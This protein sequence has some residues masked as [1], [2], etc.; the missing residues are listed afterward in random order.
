MTFGKTLNVYL[1]SGVKKV[2]IRPIK[3][4]EIMLLTDF[5]YEAI[6][7][8]DTNNLAPRTILQDPSLWIYINEFG[9]KKDDYCFVAELDDKIVGAVWVRCIKA[10]GHIDDAVPEFAISTYPQ[11]RGKG[12]GTALMRKMLEHLQ[13]KGYFKT[14][15]AV[16]KDNYAVRIYQGVGFEICGENEQEYIMVCNLNRHSK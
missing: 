2:N 5:L 4:N 15:L 13:T 9:T 14:S 16:Q 12:I 7:Q 11:Y 10:F 6:F 1:K 8:K 3:N